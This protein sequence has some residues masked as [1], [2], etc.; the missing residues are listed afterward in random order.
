MR[1]YHIEQQLSDSLDD[2]VSGNYIK[3]EVVQKSTPGLDGDFN[4]SFCF[5]LKL[6][7]VDKPIIFYLYFRVE[8]NKTIENNSV[9]SFKRDSMYYPYLA[10]VESPH[11][12]IDLFGGESGIDLKP[13]REA[14][15]AC[16]PYAEYL[17]EV[18][19]QYDAK[20]IISDDAVTFGKEWDMAA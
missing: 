8:K 17:N 10:Y 1:N 16:L 6:P 11:S 19:K 4:H 13:I 12:F 2:I 20:V 9:V 18:A 3:G 7:K 15:E 14:L 5:E